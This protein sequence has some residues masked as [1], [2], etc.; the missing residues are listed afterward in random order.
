MSTDYEAVEVRKG[1]TN[2]QRT[3]WPNKVSHYH[4]SSLNRIRARHYGYIFHQ[5]RQQNGHSS[6]HSVHG[7]SLWPARRFGTLYQTA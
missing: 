4:E 5:F 1:A 2:G 6:A 3:G 7:P